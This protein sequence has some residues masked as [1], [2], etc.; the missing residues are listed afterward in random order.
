MK[1][2][3]KIV[4]APQESDSHWQKH[5]YKGE[6]ILFDIRLVMKRFTSFA[7]L[8]TGF[9]P[10]TTWDT[11]DWDSSPPIQEAPVTSAICDPEPNTVVDHADEEI[12]LRGY[13]WS[14]GG[15]NVIRVD[16]STDG[17]KTW[18]VA[19]LDEKA[20]K[21]PNGQAWAWVP[22]EA[23]VKIPQDLQFDENGKAELE[24]CCKATDSSYNTQPETPASVW[25]L[26]GV[27]NNSFHRVPVIVRQ[28]SEDDE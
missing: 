6:I 21:Q 22:W 11:I 5:D 4:A 19:D 28:N 16:V 13:S 17:G 3:S 25:N 15:R 24:V 10:S 27:L 12:T 26:R 23:T 20:K 14:G 7:P 8:L 1:W 2:L 9:C 18:N